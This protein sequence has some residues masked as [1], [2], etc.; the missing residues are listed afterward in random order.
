MACLCVSVS[1]HSYS[2]RLLDAPCPRD[3]EVK[4]DKCL[5]TLERIAQLDLLPE[6]CGWVACESVS[7]SVR[8]YVGD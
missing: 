2:L 8:G 5:T 3:A 6:N 4:L 7:Q 1:V